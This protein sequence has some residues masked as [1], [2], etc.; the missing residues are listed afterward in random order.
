MEIEALLPERGGRGA[1]KTGATR[2]NEKH[3]KD[4][5]R[6][7]GMILSWNVY[8]SINSLILPHK[9]LLFVK[10]YSS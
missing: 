10:H 9:C 5:I 4:K 3:K 7:Q 2:S 6:R 1:V 8:W